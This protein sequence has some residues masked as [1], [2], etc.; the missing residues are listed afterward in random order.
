M[1]F[2]E[3]AYTIIGIGA[4]QK[5]PEQYVYC[6]SDSLGRSPLVQYGEK[7]LTSFCIGLSSEQRI[8]LLKGYVLCEKYFNWQE[9]SFP[10]TSYLLNLVI[11]HN[12]YD[13]NYYVRSLY[14][15]IFKNRG[16]NPYSPT[17]YGK[18]GKHSCNSYEDMV[19]INLKTRYN[20]E[21]SRS[22]IR[23]RRERKSYI[24]KLRHTLRALEKDQYQDKIREKIERFDFLSDFEK[25]ELIKRGNL[26][27]PITL[28]PEKTIDLFIE[29]VSFDYESQ[30]SEF[31]NSLPKRTN[32]QFTRRIRNS[33]S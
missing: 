13:D 10:A 12:N 29:T 3:V 18:H 14:N 28:L 8:L 2:A 27:F 24:K 17:G 4:V 6:C 20:M 23:A 15:W 25:V 16:D 1:R 11:N 9:G 21:P 22:R 31:L 7:E 30:K 32:K 5:I 26:D 19:R 33:I